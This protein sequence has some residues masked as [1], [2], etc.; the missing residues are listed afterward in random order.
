MYSGRGT[1]FLCYPYDMRLYV[2]TIL[3]HNQFKKR[4]R[5]DNSF[6]LRQTFHLITTDP[7]LYRQRITDATI[8]SHCN[9]LLVNLTCAL[10]VDIQ[11]SSKIHLQNVLS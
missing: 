1:K 8:F 3:N 7:R 5:A 9:C 11:I 2:I 10:K 4:L 6:F